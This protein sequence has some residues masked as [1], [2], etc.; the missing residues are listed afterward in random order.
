MKGP[1][2]PVVSRCCT[3]KGYLLKKGQLKWN[4][5]YF[6]L[7]A[8]DFKLYYFDSDTAVSPR[9]IVNLENTIVGECAVKKDYYGF[10]I[11]SEGREHIMGAINSETQEI[12]I[13]ALVRCGV[14]FR[15]EESAK[16]VSQQS[17]F[18]FT[19]VNIDKQEVDLKKYEG[20][21]CLVVNVASK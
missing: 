4:N 16:T 21:V 1:T 19:A 9:Q 11:V 13:Q 20:S 10:R 18:E 2:A 7:Q 6:V 12:W 3:L 14:M 5:R 17:I 15:Q 8:E